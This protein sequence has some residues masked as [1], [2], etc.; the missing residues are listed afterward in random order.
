MNSASL[1]WIRLLDFFSS[2]P[3]VVIIMACCSYIYHEVRGLT[4]VPKIPLKCHVN[5]P[6]NKVYF[7]DFMKI[8]DSLKLNTR[9]VEYCFTVI[10]YFE[11]PDLFWNNIS[12]H[13]EIIL[14][15]LEKNFPRLY[16]KNFLKRPNFEIIDCQNFPTL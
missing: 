6:S 16:N 2:L 12:S 11:I 10:P 13:S 14:S 1:I 7:T 15:Q 8:L 3:L 9:F 5:D 4:V